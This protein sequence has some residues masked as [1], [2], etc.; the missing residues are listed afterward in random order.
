[1]QLPSYVGPVV[2]AAMRVPAV[3]ERLLP[4]V[5]RR[6]STDFGSNVTGSSQVRRTQMGYEFWPEAIA[7]TLRRAATLHPGKDLV[8]TEHG[9]ATGDDAERI[10]F[11]DRGLR[12]VHA[13][14]ADGLPVRGYLYWSLLDNFEWT[15]GYRP[16]FGLIGVD[17]ATMHRTVRPSARFLGDIARRGTMPA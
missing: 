4:A 16:T 11:I 13:A 6:S 8:V 17:R 5:I 14:T 9:V 15:L 10:E 3:R 7:A 1:V 2:R 12:A